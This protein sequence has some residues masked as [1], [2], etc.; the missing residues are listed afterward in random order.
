MP[1]SGWTPK[2]APISSGGMGHM[3][4][5]IRVVMPAAAKRN[6]LACT[7]WQTDRDWVEIGLGSLRS[8]AHEQAGGQLGC[9]RLAV[10]E[11]TGD[12]ASGSVHHGIDGNE[13]VTMIAP[14]PR[15]IAS[16]NRSRQVYSR[17]TSL[18]ISHCSTA[19][20]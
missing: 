19:T 4:S 10:E 17:L 7:R 6:G 20:A 9:R 15:D 2:V 11:H 18:T 12:E 13:I 1:S 14:G 8:G 3:D 5:R 16:R